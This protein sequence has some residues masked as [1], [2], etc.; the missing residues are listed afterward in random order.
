MG[1]HGRLGPLQE[2]VEHGWSFQVL[3]WR[4]LDSQNSGTRSGASL[5]QNYSVNESGQPPQAMQMK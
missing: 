4:A 5:P 2:R 1:Q 3:S